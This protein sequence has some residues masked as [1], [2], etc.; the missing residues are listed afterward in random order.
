M[1]EATVTSSIGL[2]ILHFD[3]LNCNVLAAAMLVFGAKSGHIWT[4]ALGGKTSANAGKLC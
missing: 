2:W 3:A 4:G 1:D